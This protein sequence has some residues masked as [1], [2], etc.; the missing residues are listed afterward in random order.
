MPESYLSFGQT[1]L[2]CRHNKIR[3]GCPSL[4]LVHGLGDSG[5]AFAE[6]FED[7]RFDAFNIVAPD[8]LGYGRS[9][10]SPTRS[11]SFD[12]HLD[13]LWQI[14]DHFG[15]E[16]I[17]LVGHS[18]G[19]DLGTLLCLQ[20][21]N[22]ARLQQSSLH[23]PR[24]TRFLNVEGNLTKCDLFIS[25]EAARAADEGRFDEWFAWDFTY[26]QVFG[27]WCRS[28]LFGRRY[29]ASL[30]FCDPAAFLQNARELHGTGSEAGT[31]YRQL[32]IPK[33]FVFG[34]KSLHS[35]SRGFALGA[36]LEVHEVV[37]GHHWPMIDYA[38]DFY[39]V[40]FAFCQGEQVGGKIAE[41]QT[42]EEKAK[43]PPVAQVKVGPSAEYDDPSVRATLEDS[44]IPELIRQA[45][46]EQDRLLWDRYEG[47]QVRIADIG[48]GDGY[49]A[50]IYAPQCAFYHGYE[51]SPQMVEKARRRC[52]D[53]QNVEI[54]EGDAQQVVLGS[55]KYDV[56]WC[57]YFG[58]GNLR[59]FRK[60][61]AD[62]GGAY[63]DE[64][65]R[66]IDIIG[67]FYSAL[68]EGGSLF[69]TLYKDTPQAEEAQRSF[70]WRTDQFVL[71][72]FGS[73]FVATDKGFWSVRWTRE[74]VLHHLEKAGVPRAKVTFM[75]LNEIAWLVEA[76]K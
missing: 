73:R 61:L 29:L 33:L 60:V 11:Y 16:Q 64:N 4:L 40:L 26:R 14:I 42:C 8:L 13:C 20:E 32:P 9:S 7:E 5:L 59:E 54:I 62:Y 37:G 12:V 49:H 72:D 55:E 23:K 76:R 31:R 38:G 36:E 2:F 57:L 3:E 47:R 69:L 30:Q 52:A 43:R 39:S 45:R 15:L 17:T 71:T 51:I 50:R 41:P 24:I 22:L 74:S 27:N 44:N 56:I 19:G 67:R 28:W 34:Q 48:C 35:E 46:K 68:E 65:T 1:T 21:T 25:G 10:H 58:A 53:L 75:N 66:F 63:L 18:M 6:I 70:Y